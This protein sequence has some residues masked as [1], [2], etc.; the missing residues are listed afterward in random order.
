MLQSLQNIY[1]EWWS[2]CIFAIMLKVIVF[3]TYFNFWKLRYNYI[4]FILLRIKLG[5][6]SLHLIC[7]DVLK[8][9]RHAQNALFKLCFA[10][11]VLFTDIVIDWGALHI[12]C[13]PLSNVAVKLQSNFNSWHQSDLCFESKTQIFWH[14]TFYFGG[15]MI[16]LKIHCLYE[17]IVNCLN[18]IVEV[19]IFRE[20]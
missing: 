5:C 16:A 20:V 19:T 15:V 8:C 4:V 13:H 17:I 2:S 11:L 12:Q 7:Y 3:L 1:N 10:G 9:W 6:T 18:W 14:E